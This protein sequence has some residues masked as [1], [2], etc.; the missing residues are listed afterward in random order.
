MS[1]NDIGSKNIFFNE[2]FNATISLLF[3]AVF[4]IISPILPGVSWF[5]LGDFTLDMVNFYHTVMIPF[6]FLLMLYTSGI[7]NLNK[8]TRKSLNISTIPVLLLTLFGMIF[9]YPSWAQT[10]DYVIQALRD[11]WMV[12]LAVIFFISL[13]IYPFQDRERFKKIWG[14][15]FLILISSLSATIAAVMGM[16]YEYGVLYGYGSI[17]FFNSMVNSWGG[18]QTFLG[19]L[20]TSHSHEMLPA[21]MGGI[22]AV[23][24]ISFKYD[25]LDAWKRNVVNLGLIIS[26]AGS[27]IMTY[28]Y[29]IS[30]FGTYVIPALFTFG[31]YG[32]NGLAEDDVMTGLIGWGALISIIGLYYSIKL[33]P[34]RSNRW[35]IASELFIWLATMFVMVGIG[36]AIELNE[37][38]YGFATPGTPPNGGPGY[39]YDMAYTNGHLLFAFFMMPLMAGISLFSIRYAKD[40]SLKKASIY[41]TFAGTIVGGIGVLY[42]II[43]L[44]WGLEAIGLGMLVLSSLITT[45]SLFLKSESMPLGSSSDVGQRV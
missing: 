5:R 43:N 32:M 34:N 12:I 20:I 10:A 21:V 11:I 17:A 8:F 1:N 15:Y 40:C 38:F 23:A 28:L 9:F 44:Q 41:L 33:E 36:Y 26:V 42:Y 31:P 18:L 13:L 19:N 3:I 24:A 27:I 45:G 14:S 35:L 37:A 39:I 2:K 16:I 4:L 25:K 29:V 7:M 22:V 30:S 6:A